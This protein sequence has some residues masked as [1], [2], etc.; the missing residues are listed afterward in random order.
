MTLAPM[1]SCE[2]YEDAILVVSPADQS[3]VNKKLFQ[4][5]LIHAVRVVRIGGMVFLGFN[6]LRPKTAF[7]YIERKDS[8][9]TNGEFKVKRFIDKPEV[10]NARAFVKCHALSR[11]SGI[12]VVK[13]A[14]CMEIVD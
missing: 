12:F 5:A 14:H 11:N 6:A 1:K 4:T 9:G 13:A 7:G 8:Q 10:E 3:I 2:N